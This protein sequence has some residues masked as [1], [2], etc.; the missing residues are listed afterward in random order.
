M[1]GLNNTLQCEEFEGRVSKFK[2]ICNKL[3][4]NYEFYINMT[5]S[6]EEAT[7]LQKASAETP[8]DFTLLSYS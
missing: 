1:I 5:L 4:R 2:Y 3:N 6:D 8:H 7:E